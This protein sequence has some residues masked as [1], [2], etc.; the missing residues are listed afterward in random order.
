MLH[1]ADL[2][3]AEACVVVFDEG[4]ENASGM[5]YEIPVRYNQLGERKW[6][7]Y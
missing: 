2:I 5:E 4:I 1:P 3:K 7:R 6:Q